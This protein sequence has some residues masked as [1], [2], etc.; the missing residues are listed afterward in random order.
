MFLRFMFLRLLFF[1]LCD[2]RLFIFL[3]NSLLLQHPTRPCSPRPAFTCHLPRAIPTSLPF[4]K[5]ICIACTFLLV[6]AVLVVP[7]GAL[8]TLS[9]SVFASEGCNATFF[10]A[11]S[12]SCLLGE[13]G[14]AVLGTRE[15]TGGWEVPRSETARWGRGTSF[16]LRNDQRKSSERRGGRT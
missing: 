13:G 6:L 14:C 2:G 10:V 1:G 7:A 11:D 16:P 15:E 3:R 5:R 8:A 9:A 4:P 12:T